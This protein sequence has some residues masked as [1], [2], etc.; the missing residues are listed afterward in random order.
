[1]NAQASQVEGMQV[2]QGQGARRQIQAIGWG[3]LL[4]IT[5]GVL[6]LPDQHLAEIAWLIGVG[7]VLLGANAVRY[8]NGMPTGSGNFV[9]GIVALGA[10]LAG[11]VGVTLPWLPI[12]LILFGASL[13]A[14][15]LFEKEQ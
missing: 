5:G 6:L 1:M 11:I 4:L 3:L 8:L 12:V 9:L 2:A 13:L 14:R 15:P 7:L 10:G